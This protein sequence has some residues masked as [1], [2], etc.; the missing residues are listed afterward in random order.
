MEK[1]VFDYNKRFEPDE[2]VDREY[3]FD[4]DTIIDKG[5]GHATWRCYDKDGRLDED[6]ISYSVAESKYL[7]PSSIAKALH[8]RIDNVHIGY[9]S[10]YPGYYESVKWWCKTRLTRFS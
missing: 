10:I 8:A 2:G 9:E 3:H 1:L 4:F 5:I 7:P 6:N